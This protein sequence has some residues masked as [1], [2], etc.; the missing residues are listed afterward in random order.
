MLTMKS[1]QHGVIHTRLAATPSS[2]TIRPHPNTGASRGAAMHSYVAYRRGNTL[3]V[4]DCACPNRSHPKGD[5]VRRPQTHAAV[6]SPPWYSHISVAHSFFFRR[7]LPC[8]RCYPQRHPATS[9]YLPQTGQ[10]QCTIES[11]E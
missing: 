11:K 8:I 2:G 5:R 6:T 3:E 7:T 10:T 9:Y 4:V 1:W